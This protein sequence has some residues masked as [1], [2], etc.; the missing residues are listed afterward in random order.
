[1]RRDEFIDFTGTSTLQGEI[2]TLSTQI[3]TETSH[4]AISG[5]VFI[6]QDFINYTG[7]TATELTGVTNIGIYH[8]V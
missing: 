1:M 7:K 6:G 2:T 5:S 4:F 3:T 8:N